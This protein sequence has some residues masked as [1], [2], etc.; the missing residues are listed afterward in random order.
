VPRRRASLHPPV[1]LSSQLFV[2]QLEAAM[3]E[4]DEWAAD[5]G[6]G[7]ASD[8]S[9]SGGSAHDGDGAGESE[10]ESESESEGEGG[11]ALRQLTADHDAAKIV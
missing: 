2:E 5:G 4:A 9:G 7:R 11:G 3:A 8:D 1:A 10:L 6:D